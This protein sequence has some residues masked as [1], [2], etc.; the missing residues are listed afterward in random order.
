MDKLVVGID[1][2]TTYSLVATLRD[3]KPEVIRNSL[4]QILTPSVVSLLDSGEILVGQAAR[5]RLVTHPDRTAAL[6]KRSMGTDQISLLGSQKFRPE[7]LSAWVLR[8]LREDVEAQLGQPIHEAVVTVPAYFGELQRRATRDAC[9]IAG[10]PVERIINEPTAAALAYGLHTL[11]RELRALV[12]DL[13]GGT[14]DVTALEIIEG[15]VEI[16]ATAGD[17][18]LGGEDFTEALAHWASQRITAEQGAAPQEGTAQARLLAACEQAKRALSS[19]TEVLLELSQL[20]LQN[21][22]EQD[23]A[24]SLT[25]QQA[26]E[27][28]Q[29]ILTRIKHPIERALLDA[30]W[31]REIDEILLVGGATRMPWI[32]DL[33]R[34]LFQREPQHHLPPDEA[35]VWGA[36]IQAALKAGDETVSDLIV[37]DIAP[38]SLGISVV[39][40]VGT[41]QLEGFFLPILE[42][43]TV[44]P[45]SREERIS[46]VAD[47]QRQLTIQ[48][49]QGEHSHCSK[50][51]KLGEY[52]LKNIPVGAAGE[53]TVDVRFTY[54]LN[55]I[56]EVESTVTST[57]EKAALVIE[58]SPGRLTPAQVKKAR[59]DMQ[60]IKFHPRTALPNT[61]ALSRAETLYTELRGEARQ[62]LQ[63]AIAHFQLSLETQDPQRIDEARQLLLSLIEQLRSRRPL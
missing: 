25:R 27:L 60:R 43:G 22:R 41:R 9:E 63:Q 34:E 58:R 12:L 53:Q 24:L 48:V 30:G 26:Q 33:V 62:A 47:N 4:G 29:P 5:D 51:Q 45:A 38:F 10:L 19:Q 49:Y 8:S 50:N 36:A 7:E 35:V 39:E 32:H 3:K 61:A 54:D 57:Q 1:L 16:Q 17:S 31:T 15:I 59:T 28:W 13:G 55:G 40:T 42:R 11:D 14:F 56:L 18:R 46:T 37:T 52:S 44:L 20:P 21:K 2:G 6:F 23:I